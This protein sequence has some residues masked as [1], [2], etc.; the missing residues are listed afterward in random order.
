MARTITLSLQTHIYDQLSAT[1]S[2]SALSVDGLETLEAKNA[3]ADEYE[4]FFCGNAQDGMSFDL[5]YS[6]ITANP[7]KNYIF[8]NYPGVG[9]S[10]GDMRIGAQDLF[11]AGLQP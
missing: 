3:N 8:W 11:D 2:F 7:N 6:R 9:C 1:H 5:A 4:I 10:K